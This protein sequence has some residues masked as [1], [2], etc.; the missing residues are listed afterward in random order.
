MS[1]VLQAEVDKLVSN[2]AVEKL[3]KSTPGFYGRLFVV[4]KSTGGWR[5]VLDLSTLNQF[6]QRIPFR[7]ETPSSIRAAIRQDDW[8]TSLDLTEAYFHILIHKKYRKFLRFTWKGQVYQFRTLPFGLS[9]APWVFSR[10]VRALVR[11]IRSKG[12]RIHSYL[13]DWLI[14]ATSYNGNLRNTKFLLQVARRL[15]FHF[16]MAKSDLIPKQEF[17]FLGMLINT[18][19][20]LVS[21]SLAR[22]QRLLQLISQLLLHHTTTARRILS[23]IGMMESLAPV[24]TLGRVF[25]RPLQRLLQGQW[26]QATDNLAQPIRLDDQFT[27]A[28]VQWRDLEWLTQGVPL[29]SASPQTEIFTDASLFGWGAHTDNL[30]TSGVWTQEQSSLHINNLEMEAVCRALPFFSQ[31]AD[32]KNVRVRSDNSSVVAYINNQ[33]GARSHS[34]ST[35]AESLLLWCHDQGIALSARHIKGTSNVLADQLSRAR[36]TLPSE[37]TIAH[38]V[39]KVLWQTWFTPHVDLFASRFNHRLP[40]YVSLH[41]DPQ[42]LAVDAFSIPWNDLVAYAYPPTSLLRRVIDKARK[43]SPQLILVAPWNPDQPWFPDLLEL[44]HIPP[45]RLRL[46]EGSLRQPRSG[47]PYGNPKSLNL[48]AWMLCGNHCVHQEQQI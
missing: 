15:G 36:Q 27:A 2:F 6:L 42:A 48:H 4:P 7:M 28:I 34:L 46:R 20:L 3:A 8:A 21:P 12:I 14:P 23:L 13:D 37:W 32:L 41:P 25:K 39:L 1:N 22:T 31:Q 33:G 16:N 5:P 30:F 24:V 29:V 19:T 17:V 26:N 9:L 44:T 40:T 47:I 10:I 11:F 18:R 45:L 35:M 43:E 38:N